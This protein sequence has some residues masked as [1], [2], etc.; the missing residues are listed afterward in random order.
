LWLRHLSHRLQLSDRK[1]AEHSDTLDN[2]KM[3]VDT[4]FRTLLIRK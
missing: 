2:I 3:E 4:F 1:M